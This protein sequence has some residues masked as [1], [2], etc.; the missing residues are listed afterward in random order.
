MS[1]VLI[2]AEPVEGHFNPFLPIIKQFV[3]SGHQVLCLTGRRFEERVTQLGAQFHPLPA[4]WDSSAQEVYEFFPELRQLTGLAQIKFYIQQVMY[5]QVPD[6]MATVQTILVDFPAEVIIGDT[7]MVAGAWLAELG[8]PPSVRLSVLP[9]SLPGKNIAPFGLGLLPGKSWLGK[10]KNNAL[11]WLFEKVLFR[12]A[13]LHINQLR[14]SVGLPPYNKYF[15][16]SALES[17][18]LVLH[19]SVPAFEYPRQAFPANFHFIGPI[20][21]EPKPDFVKPTWWPQ[22]EAPHTQP[23]VLVTQGTI[24]K[25]WNNLTIPAIAALKD[26]PVKV[27]AV[28]TDTN[29]LPFLPANT[30]ST[31]YIPFANLLPHINLMITNGGF[32]GAQQA[33]AHGIP[34]VLAGTTEDKMEVA[35]RVEHSGAGINLRQQQPT[36]A[37]IKQAVQRIL[38]DPTY[39]QNATKLQQAYAEYNAPSL[40]V[41]LVEKL[42]STHKISNE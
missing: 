9:L 29:A 39:Q 11:N 13:Q 25:D 41:E 8:G 2:L 30:Y 34:L 16:I 40:A 35:A 3:T 38:A 19:T 36:P 6:I 32:G 24:S 4:R 1:N 42:I 20:L 27:I 10:L 23:V 26:E 7:F 37:A 28:P 21:N 17:H 22:L 14:Q 5:A 15:F 18:Q 31:D 33:L 12:D